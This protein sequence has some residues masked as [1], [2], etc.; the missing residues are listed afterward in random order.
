MVSPVKNQ[1]DHCGSCWTFSATGAI[2]S[3]YLVFNN[4]KVLLSEQQLVDCAKSAGDGCEG[5]D[6]KL[7]MDW[8]IDNPLATEDEY[9]YEA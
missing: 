5:G 8:T 7:A 2:E 9:P 3:A 1:G 4:F 6:Q